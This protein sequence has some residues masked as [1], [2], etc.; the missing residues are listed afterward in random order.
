MIP[1]EP[2]ITPTPPAGSASDP[3]PVVGSP[4]T[5]DETPEDKPR[6]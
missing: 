5:T 1:A 2:V 3:D 4:S 6:I